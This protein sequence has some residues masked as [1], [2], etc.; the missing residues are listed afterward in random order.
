MR[1]PRAWLS[2]S[3]WKTVIASTP[4]PCLDII[5][6]NNRREI[7]LGWR[8]IRP[9]SK[10]WALPGG[11]IRLGE[12]LMDASKR[13]LREYHLSA[14][15][16]YLVGVFP[17]NFKTRSDISICLASRDHVGEPLADGFEFSRFKWSRGLPERLGANYRRMIL[18]WRAISSRPELI[19]FNRIP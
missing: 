8:L 1:K 5:L 10:V 7:L 6:E 11:R 12:D 2:A 19:K 3:R 17:V 4:I 9:Y 16:L 15:D 18:K 14:R 13:I